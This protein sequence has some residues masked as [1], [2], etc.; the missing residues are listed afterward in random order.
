MKKFKAW[1][2]GIPVKSD[3][4]L[5]MLGNKSIWLKHGLGCKNKSFK[6][7]PS[8]SPRPVAK[9]IKKNIFNFLIL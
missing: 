3:P 8:K 1:F 5:S 2:E 4:H 6:K 9:Q 7:L